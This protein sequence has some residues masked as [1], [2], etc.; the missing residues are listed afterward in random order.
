MAD[1]LDDDDS[2]LYE[3][4]VVIV[5]TEA[6]RDWLN[7]LRDRQARLRIDDRLKRLAGGNA[8]DAKPVGDKVWELRVHLGSGYRVYYTWRGKLLI[9]LLNGGSKGSQKRDIAKAKRLAKEAEDGLESH[10]L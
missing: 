3:G 6:F 2:V 4:Q 9:V 5:Q 8:A 10:S 7:D 1:P